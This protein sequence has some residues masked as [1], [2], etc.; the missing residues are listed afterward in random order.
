MREYVYKRYIY[1]NVH[2]HNSAFFNTQSC[3]LLHSMVLCQN[4]PDS[5]AMLLPMR[6][7]GYKD[8]GMK[9]LPT[10]TVQPSTPSGSSISR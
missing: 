1:I 4:L 6:V 5:N 8:S 10:S 9:L 7:P 2:A 3:L